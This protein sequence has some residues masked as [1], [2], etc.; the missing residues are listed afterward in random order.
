MDRQTLYPVDGR[1]GEE[2]QVEAVGVVSLPIVREGIGKGVTG[3]SPPNPARS[4]KGGFR[5]G[6][7]WGRRRQQDQDIYDSVSGKGR[8]E[9]L[10]S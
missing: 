6:R 2:L 1:G 7:R 5:A 10:I 3:C 4:G 9:A 8:A